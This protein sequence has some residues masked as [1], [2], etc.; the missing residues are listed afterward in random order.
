MTQVQPIGY[1]KVPKLAEK[2]EKE[3][4]KKREPIMNKSMNTVIPTLEKELK[5][6]ENEI[7]TIPK[8]KTEKKVSFTSETVFPEKKEVIAVKKID[9]NCSDFSAMDSLMDKLME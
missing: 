8:T 1:L 4:A 5:T 6:L 3:E 7:S 2:I 9:S